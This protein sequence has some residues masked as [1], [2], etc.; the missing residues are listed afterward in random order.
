MLIRKKELIDLDQK[1]NT[2]EYKHLSKT[3][4]EKRNYRRLTYI[5]YTIIFTIL[6]TI[7]FKLFSLPI[8]IRNTI[9]FLTFIPYSLLT[10]TEYKKNSSIKEK[11]LFHFTFLLLSSFILIIHS[12]LIT[13][14]YMPYIEVQIIPYTLGNILSLLLIL[15]ILSLQDRE[16]ILENPFYSSKVK[17]LLLKINRI[18]IPLETGLT[19]FSLLVTFS[20][21]ILT[22][23][24]AISSSDKPQTLNFYTSFAIGFSEEFFSFTSIAIFSIFTAIPIAITTSSILDSLSSFITNKIKTLKN[25]KEIQT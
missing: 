4:K 9:L 5:L 22:Y 16:D 15:F 2:G 10:L 1:L 13:N 18:K 7:S 23:A 11:F 12:L 14:K 3:F 17:K 6:G 20:I 25:N 24:V 19:A 21:C 8:A